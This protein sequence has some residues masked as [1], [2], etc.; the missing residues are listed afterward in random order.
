[1]RLSVMVVLVS[2]LCLP[3]PTH[4]QEGP[5]SRVFRYTLV[6]TPAEELSTTP[7]RDQDV[8]DATN[9]QLTVGLRYRFRGPGN[10][11]SVV[12]WA[13]FFPQRVG[14]VT[15]VPCRAPLAPT[16]VMACPSS[17]LQGRRG[18][19]RSRKGVP[20]VSLRLSLSVCASVRACVRV[21]V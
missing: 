3:T 19:R 18:T 14:A 17:T 12:G 11:A 6:E 13:E 20:F 7:T 16:P 4:A 9:A 10:S 1:M 21:C 5:V 8:R 15:Y 2:S